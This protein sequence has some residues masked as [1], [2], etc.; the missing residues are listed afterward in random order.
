MGWHI[1]LKRIMYVRLSTIQRT[2]SPP[3]QLKQ[4]NTIGFPIDGTSSQQLSSALA[5]FR[6]DSQLLR[7]INQ[8]IGLNC[9]NYLQ[10]YYNYLFK[11]LSMVLMKAMELARYFCTGSVKS[12]TQYHH[13]ALN[14]PL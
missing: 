6:N 7:S 13:Y 10:H 9:A 12:Q 4:C 3:F 8:V 14:V 1:E 11:V 2:S 5:P